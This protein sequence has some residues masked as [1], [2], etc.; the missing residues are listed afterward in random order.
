MTSRSSGPKLKNSLQIR[1]F[2]LL[3]VGLALLACVPENQN[4]PGSSV[5]FQQYYV[6]GEVL[7]K[8]HCSNC[9][10]ADGVGLGRVYP[11]LNQSD[12]MDKNFEEVI[13][14]IKYGRTG[15]LSVN[16]IIY[17]QPMKGNPT[18][19]DL[20]VA[21]IVTYIYNTWSNERGLIEVGEASTVLG[22]CDDKLK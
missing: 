2:I 17:N 3:A 7:Y 18:L 12:F 20:E 11:P 6:E 14:L 5:K 1:L 4:N 22:R 9:H 21:E 19:T 15:E 8:Q 16:G 10:Q 13:C